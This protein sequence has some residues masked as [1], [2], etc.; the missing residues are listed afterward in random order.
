LRSPLFPCQLVN[1]FPS[2]LSQSVP[3]PHFN[4]PNATPQQFK[5]HT[6]MAQ[7]NGIAE[8]KVWH[9][10]CNSA[11]LYKRSFSQQKEENN[12]ILSYTNLHFHPINSIFSLKTRIYATTYIE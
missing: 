12:F 9:L 7:M 11:A 1:W 4:S 5:R 2:F 10:A 6:S 3:M 8:A